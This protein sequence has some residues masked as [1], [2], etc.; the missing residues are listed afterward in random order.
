MKWSKCELSDN[1][2]ASRVRAQIKAGGCKVAVVELLP[3]CTFEPTQ[4][5]IIDGFFY[6][7]S[8]P[9]PFYSVPLFARGVKMRYQLRILATI[10]VQVDSGEEERERGKRKQRN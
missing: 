8:C 7:L 3:G 6:P 10:S 9:L 5:L 1:S 4:V 2:A